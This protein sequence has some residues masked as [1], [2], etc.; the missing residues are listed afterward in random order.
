MKK[1]L[2]LGLALSLTLALSPQSVH[3]DDQSTSNKN[4]SNY[5]ITDR[6]LQKRVNDILN[7]GW[8]T[9][10]Y[11]KARATVRNGI[12]T[13]D[14]KV[15]DSDAKDSLENKVAELAGVKAINNNVMINNSKEDDSSNGYNNSDQK[16]VKLSDR[17]LQRKVNA[18][19]NAGWFYRSYPNV[20]AKAS[21]GTVILNGTVK[22]LQ[23]KQAVEK[24]L[25]NL[26][27]VNEIEN[28]IEVKMDSSY[29]DNNDQDRDTL[30]KQNIDDI[31]DEVFYSDRFKHVQAEVSNGS[32]TL[33]GEV[34]SLR[35]K[36][37]LN[38]EI[39]RVPGVKKIINKTT[40]NSKL[41]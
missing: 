3:S 11:P 4:Y 7:G 24:E 6:E 5:K 21:S 9:T 20:G 34:S 40:I 22:T 39:K 14:G 25:Q 26:P 17:E 32:V 35:N 36:R 27:G 16:K 33:T 15:E 1:V 29:S 13:L 28:N 37:K 18:T 41:R 19:L 30:I 12:V 38:K 8:F 23:D 2:P 31:F 10:N